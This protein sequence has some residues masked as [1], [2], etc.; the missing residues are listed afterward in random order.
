MWARVAIDPQRGLGETSPVLRSAVGRYGVLTV[1]K[2]VWSSTCPAVPKVHGNLG[3]I[4]SEF[5][6]MGKEG[7]ATACIPLFPGRV[8]VEFGL[9][10][11]IAY[12]RG[13]G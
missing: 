8:I 1:R 2:F 12:R 7:V 6:R 11:N 5:R 4:E 10:V 9:G 13:S 3:R